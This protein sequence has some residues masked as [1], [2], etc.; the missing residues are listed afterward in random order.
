M[1]KMKCSECRHWDTSLDYNGNGKWCMC[2]NPES[3]GF[4]MWRE[5][6]NHLCRGYGE[7]KE[8]NR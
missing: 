8:A 2:M 6:K 3:P 1:N 4:K 7:L 5:A